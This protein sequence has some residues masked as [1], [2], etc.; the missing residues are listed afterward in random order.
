MGETL[1]PSPL[2]VPRTHGGP[3]LCQVRVGSTHCW[4]GNRAYPGRTARTRPPSGHRAHGSA[5]CPEAACPSAG[6]GPVRPL[7]GLSTLAAQREKIRDVPPWL[8][9]RGGTVK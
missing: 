4:A 6:R 9:A 7:S 1:T 3:E 2:T 5:P 8:R